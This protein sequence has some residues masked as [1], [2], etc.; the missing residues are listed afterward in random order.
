ML[1]AP[2]VAAGSSPDPCSSTMDAAGGLSLDGGQTP[3]LG[4]LRYV[5]EHGSVQR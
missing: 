3:L 5:D 1:V 2:R 4:N